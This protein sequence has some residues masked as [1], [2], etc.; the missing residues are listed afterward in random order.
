MRAREKLTKVDGDKSEKLFAEYL[1]RHGMPYK[2]DHDVGGGNVDFYIEAKGSCVLCD[3]KEIRDSKKDKHG[4][5][6]A[7]RHIRS[8]IR[9][10]REKF[11]KDRP[12]LSL[13]LVSM[14]YSSKFFT[15]YTVARALLGEIGVVYD[16]ELRTIESPLHHLPRG[17][18][19]LTQKHCR[20]VSGLFVFN[21]GGR[22]HTFFMS[23]FADNP[24]TSGF[25]PETLEINMDPDGID[26]KLVGLG[27]M[28]FWP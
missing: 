27:E 14:N 15:G 8:D 21:Q 18:A 22:S 26:G 24:V 1:D 17:D 19:T 10:L 13:V 28:M 5:I 11:K 20:S 2:R 12:Q 9:K 6:D 4:H 3:V 16:R 23:P 25:F 7:Y